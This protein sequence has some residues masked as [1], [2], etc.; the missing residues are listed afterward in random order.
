MCNPG[1]RKRVIRIFFICI[2]LI[3]DFIFAT[4]VILIYLKVPK[5]KI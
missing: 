4:N 2:T 3:F 1:S 5:R